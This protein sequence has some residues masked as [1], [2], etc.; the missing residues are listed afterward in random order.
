MIT[1]RG[2][3]FLAAAV[4]LFLLARL[5]QVGWLYLL[6]SVLWGALLLSAILPWLLTLFLAGRRRVVPTGASEGQPSPSEG[7]SVD[8]EVLLRNRVFWP[9]FLL[10]LVYHCP[11]VTPGHQG[12][13]GVRVFVAK[14]PGSQTLTLTSRVEVN[15]RGNHSL[16]P[17]LVE[18]SGPFGL[19]RRRVKV[20]PAQPMLVYPKVFKLAQLAIAQEMPETGSRL[21]L[22][23]QGMEP[24]GAR[25]YVAGDPRRHI[26]WRNTARTGRLMVKEFQGPSQRALHLI[27]DAHHPQ[28]DGRETTLEYGIKIVASAASFAYRI[29]VQVRVYGGGLSGAGQQDN[30]PWTA[31]MRQL[32]MVAPGDG[33]SL[34]DALDSIPNGANVL[35][36]ASLWGPG[37]SIDV[38]R[39]ILNRAR[40]FQ[41]LLVVNLEG[42]GEYPAT[43]PTWI[44]DALGSAGVPVVRCR[45]GGIT[46]ALV[47]LAEVGFN[48]SAASRSP[49]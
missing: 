23:R 27:F 3:G 21:G 49:Y 14:L 28:G 39:A 44:F 19:I 33:G 43:H 7:D 4:A 31:L 48:H 16:G 8:I 11:A 20:A 41:R 12:D 35:V 15:A 30:V 17:A 2:L 13:R 5:T 38:G 34:I 18:S 22:T 37:P 1:T 47:V 25:R 32:A 9:R 26:H 45:P 10:N 36:A 46:D 6:D 24:V 40:N 42:F 29:P